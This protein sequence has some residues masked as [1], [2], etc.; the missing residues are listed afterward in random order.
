MG[1][2]AV[3]TCK[4]SPPQVKVRH[5]LCE[6]Q[7]KALEALSKIQAGERFDQVGAASVTGVADR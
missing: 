4:S 5:I 7:G 2:R 1:W 6:K 3:K